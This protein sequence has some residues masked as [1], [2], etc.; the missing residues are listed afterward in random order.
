MDQIG[1]S[2]AAGDMEG[3]WGEACV[4]GEVDIRAQSVLYTSVEDNY[5]DQRFA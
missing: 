3:Q 5:C 2:K 1:E 4:R